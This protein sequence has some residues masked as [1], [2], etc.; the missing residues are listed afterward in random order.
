MSAGNTFGKLFRV[1]T[2]G[3]S[4]SVAV[5]AVID[6][7]PAGL[8]L[9]VD[10][11]S[12]TLEKRKSRFFFETPRSE[13][14][15]PKI[16]SGVFRGRTLG[17]PIAVIVENTNTDAKGYESLEHVFRPGHA[18]AAWQIKFGLRDFRGGGRSSGRETVA[19]VLAGAVA[20]KILQKNNITVAARPKAVAGLP[21]NDD[22]S[23]TDAILQ[24]LRD[25]QASGNSC[26]G[27]VRCEVH[28][29]PAGLGEPVFS[30]LEA[31]L[32]KAVFSIGAV[33]GVEF[34]A[35]FDFA[36][37]D[38]LTANALGKNYNGGILGGISTGE[39]V[40]FTTAIKPVPSISHEQLA[41][42][43]VGT[44]VP[45][46]ILGRHD[47]CLVRRICSVI[48]AMTAITLAD[49][50]LRAKSDCM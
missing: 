44:E 18:D 25:F 26:G 9:S 24:K 17:T 33:K 36:A 40:C 2:F 19:R 42:T 23:F 3:E 50:L 32:A 43:D 15:V 1:T 8:A 39:T 4:R 38:G 12:K 49:F 37:M 14:D 46:R 6:G 45:L 22:G 30:K 10:D 7:C 29:V 48:E 5:G 31:E 16:L 28:G 35:G 34:G 47:T 27:L 21:C 11:F 13:P 20:A 41:R